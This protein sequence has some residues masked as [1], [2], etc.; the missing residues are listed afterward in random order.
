MTSRRGGSS[1]DGVEIVAVDA[2]TWDTFEE[3]FAPGGVQGGCWCSYFSMTAKDYSQS[4]PDE[5]HAHVRARVEAGTPFGLVAR[6]DGV[7]SGWVA[8][9]PRACNVRLSRSRVAAVEKGRDLSDT[10]SVVCFYSRRDARRTGLS[11]ELLDAAVSYAR[12]RGARYVEG[13]PVD[14]EGSSVPADE[15]YHGRLDVF[16]EAGFTLVERRGKRRA[17]VR[18]DLTA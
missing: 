2:G 3:L 13:Y 10:W 6:V 12:E 4:T 17:L 16:L 5:R 18:L 7:A 11:R 1:P 14:V 15:R 9:S 8:V